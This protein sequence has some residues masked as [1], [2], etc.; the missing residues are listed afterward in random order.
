M[1]GPLACRLERYLTFR[2]KFEGTYSKLP[3]KFFQMGLDAGITLYFG[4][5]VGAGFI[6]KD[7]QNPKAFRAYFTDRKCP[8][9]FVNKNGYTDEQ[10]ATMEAYIREEWLSCRLDRTASIVKIPS[11]ECIQCMKTVADAINSLFK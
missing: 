7:I 5:E 9:S 3:V 10:I 8:L 1:E 11:G 2:A 4:I 6:E